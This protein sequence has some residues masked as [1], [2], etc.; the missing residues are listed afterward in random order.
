VKQWRYRPGV[1][2][3]RPVDVYFTIVVEFVL[4]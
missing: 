3:G 1:Q 4:K 2:D